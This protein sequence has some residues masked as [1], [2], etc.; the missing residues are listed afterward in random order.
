VRLV[1][2]TL[3]A[4]QI[5]FL[6]SVRH[7]LAGRTASD[8][9]IVRVLD[10]DGI[11]GFGEAAPRPYVTG[12]TPDS[13]VEHLRRVLWPAVRG[14]TVPD[15]QAPADLGVLDRVVP[16]R[17]PETGRHHAARAGLELAIIDWA[18]RRR[19][20]SAAALVP[21]VRNRVVYGGVITAGSPAQAA[22]EAHWAR[23]AGLRAVK[24]KVGVGDDVARVRAVREVL[25]PDTRLRVDANGAWTPAAALAA[26][27]ELAPCGVVAVEQPL[28]PGPPEVLAHLRAESP[29]PLIA[30]ESVVTP[31]DLEALL[32]VGAVDGVNVRASKCGGFARSVQMARRAAA[33]GLEVQVGSHVGETAVLAA[34]GRHLAAG[35]ERVAFVEGSYGTLLLVEDVSDDGLRFGH[36]GDAPR[37]TGPGWGVRV[38]VDRLR[39]HARAVVELAA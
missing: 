1:S 8:S 5:P 33:A 13:V 10:A 16:D 26:M 35:L 27:V 6:T 20:V 22:R 38:R 15:L 29:L 31:E 18:L 4:L 3:Y 39:R 34:V 7:S 24:V 37:L 2:A 23:L 32:A 14:I 9:V 25:G 28:P 36:G 12:E 21:P 30:D 11:E 19:G 17:G